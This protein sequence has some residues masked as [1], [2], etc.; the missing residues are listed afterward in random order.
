MTFLRIKSQ[1]H[2]TLTLISTIL[3][4][5]RV[6]RSIFVYKKLLEYGEISHLKF[7]FKVLSKNRSYEE[8]NISDCINLFYSYSVGRFCSCRPKHWSA[9]WKCRLF[10]ELWGTKVPWKRLLKINKNYFKLLMFLYIFPF[11]E[12][13]SEESSSDSS[14]D[15]SEAT[16]TTQKIRTTLKKTT[17]R[18]GSVVRTTQKAVSSESDEHEVTKPTGMNC[19]LNLQFRFII[20]HTLYKCMKM[21]WEL[22][23][24]LS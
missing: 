17:S 18:S 5:W 8:K 7:Y 4:R 3:D 19:L 14:S 6:D 21:I 11:K 23:P 13:C 20:F 24:I 9:W 10:R 15:S 1:A 12:S 2:H 22:G 16:A